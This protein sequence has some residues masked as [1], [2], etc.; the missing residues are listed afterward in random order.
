MSLQILLLLGSFTLTLILSLIVIPWLK[1]QKVGQVV[2]ETGPESHLKKSGTPTMGGIVI[3]L[4]LSF[5]LIIFSFKYVELIL[6]LIVFLGFGAIGFIDDY[7]K[8]ILKNTDGLKPM[9][10]IVTLLVVST[11]FVVLYL[12]VFN[13]GTG[14]VIPGFNME[15][16]IPILLFILFN[17]F[18]LIGT[19]NAINLTDGLDG[20]L[21]GVAIIIITFFS[22]V[23]YRQE[24]IA[25]LILGITTIGSTF[26]F[27]IFNK[28]PAKIF[29]GDTGSLALGGIIAV[30]AI[31]LKMPL[32]LAIVAII[33]VIETLSVASQVIYFKISK[34]KR[35]FK[36]APIHHHFELSGMKETKV[37]NVFWTI[38]LIAAIIAYAIY[39]I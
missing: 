26:A 14:I 15:L 21:S 23:A 12:F 18:I 1:K 33:P 36:M 16:E 24:N 8:L 10:K 3:L 5:I 39:C 30:M 11:L 4:A 28:Y 32:Y 6:P 35:L 31:M 17:I 25:M 27:L 19:S 34:G 2:R 7:K 9:Q 38:T 22:I 37:V 13:L 29:M 20:L